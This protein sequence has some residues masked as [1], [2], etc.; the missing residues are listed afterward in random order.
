MASGRLEAFPLQRA[1]IVIPLL[2]GREGVR[3][4]ERGDMGEREGVSRT[5]SISATVNV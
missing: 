2:G 1:G 3:G 4:W 5:A